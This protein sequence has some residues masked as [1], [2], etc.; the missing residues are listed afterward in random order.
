MSQAKSCHDYYQILE[1][2]QKADIESIKANYKRLAR[3]KHPDKNLNNPNAT[4]EFQLIQ[5]A[6][7][8][9]KDPVSRK[10]YDDQY[11][12]TNHSNGESF[13]TGSQKNTT[14]DHESEKRSAERHKKLQELNE[15]LRVQERNL[16]DSNRHLT[17][18]KRDA[19]RL[20][21][22]IDDIVR[23][24]AAKGTLW[25]KLYWEATCNE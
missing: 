4:A 25:G 18:L 10:Q 22:E 17:T 14:A 13:H 12:P 15:Q 9:L 5:E 7:S 16:F 24:Q 21:T 1:I 11:K 19:H 6:Y 3:L 2:S 8:T 20:E 23:K